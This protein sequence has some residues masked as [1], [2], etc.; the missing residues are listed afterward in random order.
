MKRPT[1][2]PLEDVDLTW[3]P[4]HYTPFEDR[5][6][7]R[8]GISATGCWHW[9]GHTASGYGRIRFEQRAQLIHR[10][11]FTLLVGP[12]PEGMVLDHLCRNTRC[13]NPAHLEVVTIQT[14]TRRGVSPAAVNAVKT[15]CVNGHPFD[16]QNTRHNTNGKRSCR[17]CAREWAR[18]NSPARVRGVLA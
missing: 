14:N 11:V 17:A 13:C 9:T 3:R 16:A 4:H 2:V 10:L 1:L 6:W 15:E 12:I 5:L 7:R 18:R 8:V